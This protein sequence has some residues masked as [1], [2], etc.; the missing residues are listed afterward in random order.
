MS[1]GQ[2]GCRSHR[3]R[4][5]TDVFAA[6]NLVREAAHAAGFPSR[7]VQEL[8]IAA[9]ELAAN[10]AKHGGGG[11]LSVWLDEGT[12]FVRAEDEGPPFDDFAATFAASSVDHGPIPGLR[13]APG[14]GLGRGLGA[15]GRFSDRVWHEVDGPRKAVSFARRLPLR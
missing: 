3:V 13:L 12:L 9:S 7:A 5:H 11:V 6:R 15:V 4:V 2:P 8:V 10:L 1:S 14:A